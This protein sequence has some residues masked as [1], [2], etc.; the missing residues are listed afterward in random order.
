MIKYDQNWDQNQKKIILD[1]PACWNTKQNLSTFEVVRQAY[2]RWALGLVVFAS[3][4]SQ[5][6]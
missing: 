4:V 1:H 3:H 2:N 6:R 5:N